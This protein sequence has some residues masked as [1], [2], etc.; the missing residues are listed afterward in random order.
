MQAKRTTLVVPLVALAATIAAAGCG[1]SASTAAA[2]RVLRYLSVDRAF[3]PIGVERQTPRVGDR[4]IFKTALYRPGGDADAPHGKPIGRS[5]AL[6]TVTDAT[7]QQ[8]LCAG[9]VHL[10]G[11]FLLISNSPASPAQTEAHKVVTAAVTGGVGAYA[12]ARG[13]VE[14]RL[15]SAKPSGARVDAVVIRLTP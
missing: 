11:G 3:V 10:S 2:P 13:T 1:S 14:F 12:N 6:C 15:L 7:T 8:T 9:A 5:E 4:F